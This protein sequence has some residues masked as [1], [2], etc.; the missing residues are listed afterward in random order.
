MEAVGQKPFLQKR[1]RQI[2]HRSQNSKSKSEKLLKPG[3]AEY[4]NSFGKDYVD[5]DSLKEYF[6]PSLK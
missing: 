4:K 1:F 2:S 3:K 6:K 5:A